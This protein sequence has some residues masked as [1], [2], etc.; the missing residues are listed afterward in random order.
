MSVNVTLLPD[1]I[2]LAEAVTADMARDSAPALTVT[3]G[4]VDVTAAPFINAPIV[5]AVPA[6][7]AVNVVV[8]V[9]LPLS[10]VDPIVPLLV[11]PLRLNTT[12]AP[13]A[14][15]LLPLASLVR[16]VS[17]RLLPEDTVAL[18]T[19]TV[20]TASER[21]PGVTVIVGNELVIATPPTVAFTVVAVP[22]A[23]PVKVA[24]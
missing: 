7:W 11:P 1:A 2:E 22:A 21:L 4:S 6:D 13:P 5:V 9:P 10:V 20:D 23:M 17:V 12:V 15:R 8:Y 18:D 24:V 14:G 19:V 16:S 3:V